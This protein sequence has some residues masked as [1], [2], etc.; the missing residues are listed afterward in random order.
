MDFARSLEAAAIATIE[1]GIMTGD[2]AKLARPAATKI[3]STGEFIDEIAK[4]IG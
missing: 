1:A 4:A 3:C 2:L